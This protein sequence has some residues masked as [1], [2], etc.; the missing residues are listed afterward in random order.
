MEASK[1][2]M[3]SMRSNKNNQSTRYGEPVKYSD[4]A[5]EEQSD[6]DDVMSE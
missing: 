5:I 2:L 1:K 6:E 3:Q 4:K